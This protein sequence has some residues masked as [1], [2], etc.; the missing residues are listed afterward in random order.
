MVLESVFDI[1]FQ[2]VLTYYLFKYCLPPLLLMSPSNLLTNILD[3][4]F[5]SQPF[6]MQTMLSVPLCFIQDIFFSTMYFTNFF[7]SYVLS[8]ICIHFGYCFSIS[9][10][11]W[12]F[13][14]VPHFLLKFLILSF[15]FEHCMHCHFKT[16]VQSIWTP[17]C[18]ST[19]NC[20]SWIFF[21]SFFFSRAW[22]FKL[23]LQNCLQ[24]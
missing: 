9:E 22:F 18:V 2:E 1:T 24:K 12:F 3:L 14:I 11:L 10:L 16:S 20:F 21:V 13:F 19:S 7:F 8:V 23:F 17:R 6:P 5:L 4:C 15:M